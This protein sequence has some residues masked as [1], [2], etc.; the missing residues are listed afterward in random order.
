[1]LRFGSVSLVAGTALIM[2]LAGG[3]AATTLHAPYSGKVDKLFGE[4]YN[5]CYTLKY[6]V[7]AKMSLTTG[8]AVAEGATT[9]K[10]CSGGAGQVYYSEAEL[11]A[12]DAT[13]LHLHLG[14][15]P[16][17]IAVTSAE[18]FAMTTNLSAVPNYAKCPGYTYS[19]VNA[20]NGSY[21]YNS[22]FGFCDS[23][24]ES[25]VLAEP[26]LFDL[27][28]GTQIAPTVY[29]VDNV[30]EDI[31]EAEVD[32]VCYGP[33]YAVG[34][35]GCHNYNVTFYDNITQSGIGPSAAIT[36][37]FSG[38]TTSYINGTFNKHHTYELLWQVIGV[39]DVDVS[40][41]PGASGSATFDYGSSGHGVSLKS[42][43]VT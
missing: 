33:G 39:A 42:I 14:N 9:A 10:I 23:I 7:K 3:A 35:A 32:W 17:S 24:A 18:N 31:V 2:M 34:T 37:G 40:E 16:H 21:D 28:N 19:F 20:T 26:I 13:L 8:L 1:M 12:G 36:Q 5:G 11:E 15:G 38:I 25:E 4:F 6:P 22:T 27:T 30:T 29:N 41:M 43:T